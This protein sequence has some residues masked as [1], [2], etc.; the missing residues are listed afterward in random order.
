MKNTILAKI[1]VEG[2]IKVT[3]GEFDKYFKTFNLINRK[4]AI[5]FFNNLRDAEIDKT[6]II[7]DNLITE[8]NKYFDT[9]E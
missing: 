6:N 7:F 4:M 5:S 1:I 2:E 9:I 3:Q 8:S